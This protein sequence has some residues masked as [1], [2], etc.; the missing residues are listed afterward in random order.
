MSIPA[1]RTVYRIVVGDMPDPQGDDAAYPV[2]RP[3]EEPSVERACEVAARVHASFD[4]SRYVFVQHDNWFLNPGG[5]RTFVT[6]PPTDVLA[7]HIESS[8]RL[9]RERRDRRYAAKR[10]ATRK[11]V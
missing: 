9:R 3:D 5:W 1:R 11:R 10:A 2:N 6:M 8:D 4:G 7:A